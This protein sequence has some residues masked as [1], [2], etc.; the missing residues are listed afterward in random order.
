M[1]QD[2]IRELV[3][4]AA[5]SV[6][7]DIATPNREITGDT[8]LFGANGLCDSLGLVS[9]VVDIEQIVLDRYGITI[10]LSDERAMSQSR[11]PFLTV[12]TLTDYVLSL[13]DEK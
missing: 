3:I 11:S 4:E 1:K 7:Y 10:T 12:N 2:E 5:Q 8:R 6:S 9:L 13:I